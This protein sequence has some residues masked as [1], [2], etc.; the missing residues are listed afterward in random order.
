MDPAERGG[1]RGRDQPPDGYSIAP[2]EFPKVRSA[3]EQSGQRPTMLHR[4]RPSG[5]GLQ[6]PSQH[7][8]ADTGESGPPRGLV[9]IVASS[10]PST[11]PEKRRLLARGPTGLRSPPASQPQRHWVGL[12]A[13][14]RGEVHVDRGGRADQSEHGL[15]R[16]RN[17]ESG[18]ETTPRHPP[19]PR[20]GGDQGLRSG[21]VPGDANAYKRRPRRH[22]R[23]PPALHCCRL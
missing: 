7:P 8:K 9:W 22:C 18:K 2:T 16:T 5:G 10:Q 19:S 13:S 17:D 12:P 11:D 4:I 6:S 20:R 15:P 23:R 1:K 14:A 3:V 21:K